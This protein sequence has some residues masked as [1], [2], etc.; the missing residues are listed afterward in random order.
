M[1]RRVR[2][3]VVLGTRS[4]V[5]TELPV[6]KL[7]RGFE[8]Y[9]PGNQLHLDGSN[10]VAASGVGQVLA[11]MDAPVSVIACGVHEGPVYPRDYRTTRHHEWTQATVLADKRALVADGTQNVFEN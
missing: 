11:F 1:N 7:W 8:K 10:A 2:L 6:P 3:T 9:A 4:T 5:R